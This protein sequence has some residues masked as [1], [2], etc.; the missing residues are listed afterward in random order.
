MLSLPGR[1]EPHRLLCAQLRAP[2]PCAVR[3][4]MAGALCHLSKLQGAL[5][6]RQAAADTAGS[7]S[8][9]ATS[10]RALWIIGVECSK[11]ACCWHLLLRHIQQ[12]NTSSVKLPASTNQAM[13]HECPDACVCAPLLQAKVT[14]RNIRPLAGVESVPDAPGDEAFQQRLAHKQEQVLT[15]TAAAAKLAGCLLVPCVLPGCCKAAPADHSWSYWQW[16]SAPRKAGIA[17]D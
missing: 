17:A 9:V 3:G 5:L 2:L 13:P 1:G 14:R 11:Y 10:S 15:H 4:N 16:L 7:T 12:R 8:T 6:W